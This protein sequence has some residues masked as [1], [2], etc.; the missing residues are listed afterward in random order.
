VASRVSTAA[1][2]ATLAT[3]ASSSGPMRTASSNAVHEVAPHSNPA[4]KENGQ[5]GMVF[6]LPSQRQVV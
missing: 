1:I 2:W 3:V 6:L 5:P 4:A